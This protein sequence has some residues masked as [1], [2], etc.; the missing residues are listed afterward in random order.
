M[1]ASFY[2][3][4]LFCCFFFCV[5]SS[6]LFS[7]NI[8][9]KNLTAQE[10]LS[11]NEVYDA[12]QDPFGVLWFATDRGICTYDGY[13]FTPV[14]WR[15]NASEMAVFN[16][17]PQQD[18]TIWF[19]DAQNR[20]YVINTE[21]QSVREHAL[22]AKLEDLSND[23][24]VHNFFI[25]KSGRL[26]IGYLGGIGSTVLESDGKIVRQVMGGDGRWFK[27]D[28][29]DSCYL[30]MELDESKTPFM[31]RELVSYN[32]PNSSTHFKDKFSLIR[33][34]YYKGATTGS[35][36]LMSV[37]NAV[38][39][40]DQFQ[41]K[42]RIE[43]EHVPISLG[44]LSSTEFWVGYRYGGF[45]TY[46]LD[47]EVTGHYFE[48]ES[49]SDLQIDHEGSYW[50][51]TLSSGVFYCPSLEILQVPIDN[52]PYVHKLTKTNDNR[53][54]V[55][56]YTG[57]T[58]EYIN[59]KL[60][61][62]YD[63]K[64]N[65]P[66]YYEEFTNTAISVRD[67][68]IIDVAKNEVLRE[69]Y[70]RNISEEKDNVPVIS[71]SH[72]FLTYTDQLNSYFVE[73][74]VNSAVPLD[75]GILLAKRSGLFLYDTIKEKEQ[76]IDHPLLNTWITET[77]V[78]GDFLVAG[79]LNHGLVLFNRKDTFDIAKKDGLSSNHINEIYVQDESTLWACTNYG[80]N[81]IRFTKDG[82]YT[83]DRIIRED[84]L[85]GNEVTDIEILGDSL[86]IVGTRS[87]LCAL[88]VSLIDKLDKV[89]DYFLRFKQLL[90][91]DKSVTNLTGL[92]YDQNK[93]E[94]N[95]Q[96]LSFNHAGDI[97]FRYKLIGLDKGWNYTSS[98]K[99]LYES[100][101]P[102]SYEF[103][104]QLGNKDEWTDN[105]IRTKIH[106]AP[107]FYKTVPFITLMIAFILIVIYA[108]FKF[109]ILSYNREIFRELMR[110]LL[111]RLKIN[112]NSFVVRE[113]GVDIRIISNE[114]LYVE[115]HGNYI[116]IV[117]ENERYVIRE[118]ISNFTTIV[119]DPL[120]F[121]QVRRNCIVRIDKVSKKSVSSVFIGKHEIKVGKTFAGVLDQI[122]L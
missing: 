40:F 108:F 10:G 34:N 75:E 93:I 72:F 120:E 4:I 70:V 51:T 88:P 122:P 78:F 26:H 98:L 25:D 81:R 107:P 82:K 121:I 92:T 63:S 50:F 37:N 65:V 18:S 2:S 110:Q 27:H 60:Q 54:I 85:P 47:G 109:R 89:H 32:V 77:D 111:K 13:K 91:N 64:L 105:I 22:S 71:C 14:S 36:Q 11:S 61:L 113:K 17:F 46:N 15:D 48:N 8:F 28:P 102:G 19:F 114:V 118:K 45:K 99:I 116:E 33:T 83:I 80:L 6:N 35:Y 97:R 115:S 55:N 68:Q 112:N 39:L 49:I 58:F 62:L 84:G 9:Y 59:G 16:L 44:F 56:L 73:G 3:R 43:S 12:Y 94:L 38:V 23:F 5:H 106:I 69:V 103:I 53:I 7:Q 30:V 57:G 67:N 86:L 42:L 104:L 21:S 117:T 74:F 20:C 66:S 119:P 79:T 29:P 90:V 1:S 41:E 76:K 101:P 87:G 96:A 52:N 24:V 100:I 31:H 95:Y